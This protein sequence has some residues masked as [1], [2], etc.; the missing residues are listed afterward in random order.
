MEK[1]FTVY[2]LA[3]LNRRLYT[4]ITGNIRARMFRHK[5]GIGS[6]F[7]ARYNINRLV[8][9]ENFQYASNAIAR[10]K[11]IKTFFRTRKLNMIEE[12][13]PGWVDLAE[14]WFTALELSEPLE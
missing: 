5:R 2:I 13:N 14:N 4:G 1:T 3:S 8:Y 9:Y 10:E 12:F 6:E 11:E 7:A